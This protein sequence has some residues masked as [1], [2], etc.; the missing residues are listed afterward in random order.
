MSVKRIASG[1]LMVFCSLLLLSTM[2][3]AADITLKYAGQM[4][5]THHLTQA[6]FRFAKMVEEKTDGKVKIEVYPAGQLYKGNSI[7]K[8]VMSGAIDMGM[9]YNGT[10][11]S[12]VPLMDVFD[13]NFLFSDYGQVA[14]AWKGKVGDKLRAEMEKYHVKAL[15]FGAYGESFCIISINKAIKLPKDCV[16]LK[17]RANQPMAADSVKALGASPVMMSSSEVYM[18]LQRGT[19]DGTTSG[20]TSFIQRKWYEVCKH[21]TLLNASYSLWPMMINLNVWNKLPEEVKTVLQDCANDYIEYTIKMSTIEDEKAF[22]IL[23]KNL[24]VVELSEEE[25]QIWVNSMKV[26]KDDFIERA[27]EDGVKLLQW[28]EE[29]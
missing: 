16:G 18:A 2:T 13:I 6:D 3:L 28:I 12:S 11:T 19:I 25:R 8:A 26:V 1:M 27:G 21:A 23:R 24:K 17:I 7:V 14:E 4:P 22:E 29:M 10:W 15:G 20:P 9:T 5:V